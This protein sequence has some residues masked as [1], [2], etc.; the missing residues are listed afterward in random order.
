MTAREAEP[1]LDPRAADREA[2]FAALGPWL[3]AACLI[4]MRTGWRRGAD[5]AS[6][7][8]REPHHAGLAWPSGA[9]R[10]RRRLRPTPTVILGA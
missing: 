10:D 4:E 1:E 2:L 7:G 5:E 9:R 6:Q 3:H 8:L